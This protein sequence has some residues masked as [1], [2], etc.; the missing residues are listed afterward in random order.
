[1]TFVVRRVCQRQLIFNRKICLYQFQLNYA[2]TNPHYYSSPSNL[3]TCG[4]ILE[5]NGIPSVHNFVFRV[6]GA[7]S[8]DTSAIVSQ[9]PFNR[10]YKLPDVS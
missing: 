8:A 6:L 4:I 10:D 7:Y 1:M 3:G 2:Y 5:L 9:I